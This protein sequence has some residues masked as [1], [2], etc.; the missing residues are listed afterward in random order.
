MLTYGWKVNFIKLTYTYL[1]WKVNFIKLTYTYLWWKVNLVKL[2][3]AYLQWEVNFKLVKLT[4][5]H[6]QWK[7]TSL[8]CMRV[9]F[10]VSVH[11]L[12]ATVLPCDVRALP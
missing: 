7:Y 11:N 4:R 1:Q 2:T 6:L 10:Q 3:Y 12:V 9:Q 8:L 5:G